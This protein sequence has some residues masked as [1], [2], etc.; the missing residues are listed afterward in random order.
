MVVV[1]VHL[2]TLGARLAR[3]RPA[4]HV[5]EYDGRPLTALEVVEL[6]RASD[7]AG[8][9]PARRC[10]FWLSGY[11]RDRPRL[12]TAHS[13]EPE[14]GFTRHVSMVQVTLVVQRPGQAPRPFR[15]IDAETVL[16]QL[17]AWSWVDLPG[18][19]SFC[20]SLAESGWVVVQTATRHGQE[21][22]PDRP[23]KV[24]RAAFVRTVAALVDTVA[25]VRAEADAATRATAGGEAE[26]TD[27]SHH[28]ARAAVG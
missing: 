3:L 21:R 28:D 25:A 24:P 17:D 19:L 5:V 2:A 22:A 18:G 13:T 10:P 1:R 16:G 15:K 20:A 27:D 11:D 23:V 7:L 4:T 26:T 6:Y 12:V 9:T 14:R 8:P